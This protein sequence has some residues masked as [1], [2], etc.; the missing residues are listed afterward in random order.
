M[1]GV[2]SSLKPTFAHF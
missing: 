1:F 2:R